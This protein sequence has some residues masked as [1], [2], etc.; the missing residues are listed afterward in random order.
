MKVGV[1]IGRFQHSE[2]TSGHKVLFETVKKSAEKVIVLVGV[3][4][5][6]G[7]K[8]NPLSYSARETI[9]KDYLP[10]IFYREMFSIYPLIDTRH[11]EDWSAQVDNIISTVTNRND[12]ITLYGGRDSFIPNYSG[13]HNTQEID[14]KDP[15]T[16]TELRNNIKEKNSVDFRNG[17][18]YALNNPFPHQRAVVDMGCVRSFDG[19]VHVL[20]GRKHGE[21]TKWRLPGGFADVE[22][23]CLEDAAIREFKEETSLEPETKVLYVSSRKIDDWRYKRVEEAKI[24][25]SLFTF[26]NS[27]GTPKAG[28]DLAEIKWFPLESAK[29]LV[30]DLHKPFIEDLIMHW[31]SEVR[32]SFHH[33]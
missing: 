18:I 4:F 8:R 31:L 15:S 27:R 14:S 13:R 22:D 30:Q 20:L 33:V 5:V 12:E 26:Q 28:D 7:T 32:G 3:P 19:K 24:M 10:S 6:K 1:V 21:H 25:S 23:L 9:L 17:I 2:L 29:D 16:A 11:D